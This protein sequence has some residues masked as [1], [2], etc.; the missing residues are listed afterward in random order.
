[1][2]TRAKYMIVKLL[3]AAGLTTGVIFA[4]RYYIAR[5][6]KT[7]INVALNRAAEQ[8]RTAIAAQEQLLQTTAETQHASEPSAILTSLRDSN[9]LQRTGELYACDVSVIERGRVVASSLS[10]SE[11]DVLEQKLGNSPS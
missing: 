3:I 9:W 5:Q 11:R 2:T 7:E 4:L 10:N 8:V 1:M 6:A